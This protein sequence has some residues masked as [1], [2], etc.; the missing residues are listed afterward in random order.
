MAFIEKLVFIQDMTH[1]AL[2]TD[3]LSLHV[4]DVVAVLKLEGPNYNGPLSPQKNGGPK[5]TFT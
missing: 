4:R 2:G 1:K 3:N 5:Y